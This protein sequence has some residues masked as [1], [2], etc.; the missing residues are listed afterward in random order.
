MGYECSPKGSIL[1]STKFMEIWSLSPDLTFLK[2]IPVSEEKWLGSFVS[3]DV[4]H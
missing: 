3:G 1:F 4:C 2:V